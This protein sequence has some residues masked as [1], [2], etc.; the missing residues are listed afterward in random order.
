MTIQNIINFLINVGE[1]RAAE[2]LK[3]QERTKAGLMK[4]VFELV[5]KNEAD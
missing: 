3:K 2:K 5:I 4:M 1:E